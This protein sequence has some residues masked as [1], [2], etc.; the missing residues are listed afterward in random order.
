M[1]TTKKESD[2]EHPASHYLVVEDPESPS[3]WHLRVKDADGQPDHGLMGAA[4]AA[5]HEGYR[6]NKYEGPGMTAAISKLKKMYDSEGMDTPGAKMRAFVMDEFVATSPGD[7]YRLFPF[8]PLYHKGTMKDITPEYAAKFKLPHFKPPIL[9]GSHDET[10]P[11][12]GHIIGLEV[13]DD[14]LYALPEMNEKGEQALQDGAYRYHSPEVIWDGYGF[15]DPNTGALIEGPLIVGDAL[16]HVPHLGEAAALYT[17]EPQIMKEPTMSAE[18]V[19]V[20]TSLWEQ[21]T[22]KLLGRKL[23]EPAGEPP[24]TDPKAEVIEVEKFNALKKER[25]EFEAK[26]KAIEAETARKAEVAKLVAE[27]QKKDEKGKELFGMSYVELGKAEEAATMLASMT[28][29]QR[30]WCMR[31]FKAYAAQIDYSKV[32]GEK[33]KE[34]GQPVDPVTAMDAAIK[35]EMKA[36]PKLNYASAMDVVRA[37][38]P[39][40]VEKYQ[41]ATKGK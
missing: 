5:L 14:G 11:A 25:D 1:A 23:D 24:K 32:L 15:E 6:G 35:A 19:Q 10:T 18:M 7:P 28:P 9:L 2:G 40:L 13:R 37:K 41:A 4:W 22:A 34:G 38:S 8:G 33:G 29:E 31:N 26:V 30:E 17:T 21:L 12:G 36:D 3:T 20:P 27:L 39:E 16:L